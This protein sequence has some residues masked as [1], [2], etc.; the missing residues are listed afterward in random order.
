M[1]SENITICSVSGRIWKRLL[2]QI[3][4]RVVTKNKTLKMDN[5]EQG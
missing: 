1:F 5:M 4:K 3:T 2:W